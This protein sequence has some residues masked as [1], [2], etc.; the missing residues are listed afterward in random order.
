METRMSDVLCICVHQSP[1][2]R[3]NSVVFRMIWRSAEHDTLA[4]DPNELTV[5]QS[6]CLD[7]LDSALT[8]RE[9]GVAK[10]GGLRNHKNAH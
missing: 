3:S 5:Q 10:G 2:R 1:R 8:G 7:S 4:I 6:V 9:V